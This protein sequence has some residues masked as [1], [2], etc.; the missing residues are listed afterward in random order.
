MAEQDTYIERRRKSRLNALVDS[1]LGDPA[2][3]S[4]ASTEQLL[5][6][7]SRAA[8]ET[9][10]GVRK[11][12]GDVKRAS[13]T[14]GDDSM[15]QLLAKDDLQKAERDMAMWLASIRG[16][17]DPIDLPESDESPAL[18][19]F[20]GVDI[21]ATEDMTD[22]QAKRLIDTAGT[23]YSDPSKI[24]P[25]EYDYSGLPAY[26]Q[27]TSAFR[28][29]LKDVEA[30]S[31]D[32]MF[33]EAHRRDTPFKGTKI[34]NLTM[35]EVFDLV[36][37]GG[38]WNQY[39]KTNHDEN[40]TAIGKYQMV[41]AT[42]RDLKDRGVLKKLGITGDTK[43]NKETQDAIAMHLAERRVKPDYSM[44]EARAQLKNEWAGFKKLSNTELD[45]IINEIRGS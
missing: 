10:A 44:A 29:A 17:L 9:G 18:D 4:A 42:L 25:E 8:A 28:T 2:E 15:S 12:V 30:S 31:Y 13:R 24:P 11:A 5:G 3:K 32:T 37:A 45:T 36:A 22:A 41:G 14:E 39:N 7:G 21:D 1:I 40:T 26:M 43:F 23:T 6:L 34:T 38:E 35:D 33:G 27:P 16:G 19:Y 20:Q